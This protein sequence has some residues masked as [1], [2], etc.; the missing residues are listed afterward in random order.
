MDFKNLFEYSS[1]KG[2]IFMSFKT[3]FASDIYHIRTDKLK[4]TQQQVADT[5]SI[6]LRE[7]QKIEKGEIAPGSEIFLRLVFF[8]GV[9]I[10]RYR[11]DLLSQTSD[12]L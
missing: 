7:Y 1:F 5:V 8:L 12:T 11:Q 9:D 3:H 2:G 6:S 4:L 10:E